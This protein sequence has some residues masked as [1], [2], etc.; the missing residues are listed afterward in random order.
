MCF[1]VNRDDW[2]YIVIRVVFPMINLCMRFFFCVCVCV[3][4][5]GNIPKETMTRLERTRT[6][7]VFTSLTVSMYCLG[8]WP[9]W[10]HENDTLLSRGRGS[11][12][13]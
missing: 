7:N 13:I 4:V 11:Y 3:C 9:E 5:I 12:Q 6:I 8:F 1:R 10:V 2:L